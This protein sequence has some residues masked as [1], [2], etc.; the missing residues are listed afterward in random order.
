VDR[1][2]GA[3]TGVG[4]RPP[5]GPV[6]PPVGREWSRAAETSS[7]PR[8]S[9]FGPAFGWPDSALGGYVPPGASGPAG[10]RA[11][12]SAT[13]SPARSAGREERRSA[14]KPDA[15]IPGL[16]A[17]RATSLP[18]STPIPR[19]VPPRVSPRAG[20]GVSFAVSAVAGSGAGGCGLLPVSGR[21][22]RRAT[23]GTGPGVG[24][25][26]AG[27]VSCD[28]GR[29]RKRAAGRGDGQGVAVGAGW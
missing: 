7:L 4:S 26:A 18:G 24:R 21:V 22:S 15:P 27:G 19:L 29:G 13:R 23:G 16:T 8:R 17:G 25:E 12:A 14:R 28:P 5:C 1:Q 9:S 3:T 11:A 6:L 10:P 2:S 20:I